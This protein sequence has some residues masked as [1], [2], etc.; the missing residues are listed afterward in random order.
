MR[1][2][3]FG[4]RIGGLGRWTNE[5]HEK[6]IHGKQFRWNLYFLVQ[7]YIPKFIIINFFF[8]FRNFWKRLVKSI[9]IYKNQI[10]CSN[11]ISCPKIF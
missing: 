5:E 11:K 2:S 4:N 6:F 3:R 9:I 1:R 10:K 8:S 7:K